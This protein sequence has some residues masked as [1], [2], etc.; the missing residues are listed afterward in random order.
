M[1][2]AGGHELAHGVKQA[3]AALSPYITDHAA[4]DDVL[5]GEGY[6]NGIMGFGWPDGDA[7]IALDHASGRPQFHGPQVAV[8][9]LDPDPIVPVEVNELDAVF[10]RQ[11]QIAKV[12]VTGEGVGG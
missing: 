10:I 1:L 3:A 7:V 12:A 4:H 8:V 9:D 5:Q 11:F 2:Q 6:Q